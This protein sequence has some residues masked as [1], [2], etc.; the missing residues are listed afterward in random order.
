MVFMQGD[1]NLQV[2]KRKSIDDSF[3][4]KQKKKELAK[5]ALARL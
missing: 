5:N 4:E 1:N 2:I 3:E